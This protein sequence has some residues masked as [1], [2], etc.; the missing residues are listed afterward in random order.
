MADGCVVLR[1]MPKCIY[2]RVHGYHEAVLPAREDG[3]EK[4]VVAIKPT[5]RRWQF[6]PTTFARPVDV[7]R[8]QVP[9][10]PRKQ[11]TLHGVQGK[12]GTPGFIVHW[13]YPRLLSAE[14]IWLA[15]Y[16]SLSRPKRLSDLLSHGLPSREIIEKGPPSEWLEELDKLFPPEKIARTKEAAKEAR[17]ILQWPEKAPW[18][19]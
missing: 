8:T 15:H 12:T 2:V 1:Y 7:S 10:L 17:R 3:F 9:L 14:H 13:C 4:G 11:C 19:A 5:S 6:T 18:T 16:V